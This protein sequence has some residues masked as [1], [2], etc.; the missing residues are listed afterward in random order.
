MVP[1]SVPVPS[2]VQSTQPL[3]WTLYRG[4][5]EIPTQDTNTDRNAIRL[6]A[7][8]P[9]VP[10]IVTVPTMGGVLLI[11]RRRTRY[12]GFQRFGQSSAKTRNAVAAAT[13]TSTCHG[14][15]WISKAWIKRDKLALNR[16]G[17]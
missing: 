16:Y 6:E 14:W 3:R 2:A 17:K 15:N 10:G 1:V 12:R 7:Y 9:T 8:L 11:L 4:R 13:T 5:S